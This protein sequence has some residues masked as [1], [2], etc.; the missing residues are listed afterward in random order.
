MDAVLF[1]KRPAESSSQLFRITSGRICW[2]QSG[3]LASRGEERPEQR[4]CCWNFRHCEIEGQSG[5]NLLYPDGQRHEGTSCSS[6]IFPDRKSTR[7]NSSHL[8][9]SYAVFCL[10]K[11]NAYVLSLSRPYKSLRAVPRAVQSTG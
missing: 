6:S 2:K 1:W 7:L 10:K 8:V 3:E 9:I 5:T 11:S 4:L